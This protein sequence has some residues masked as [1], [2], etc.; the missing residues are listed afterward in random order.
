[1]RL[2]FVLP[3]VFTNNPYPLGVNGSLW[4]IPLEVR[5]YVVLALAG[6]F[7]LMRSKSIWLLIIAAFIAWFIVKSS[8]DVTGKIHYGRELSAFFLVG[9]ALFVLQSRW[10]RRPMLWLL[11]LS[12]GAALV[13]WAGWHYTA[14]LI[15]LPFTVIYA[16]TR[17]TPVIQHFGRWGD[18]SYGIY[19][20]AY[21]VQ[22]TVIHFL[23]PN[24]GFVG[25]MTLASAITVVLA[26]AS[27]HGVEKTALKFKPHKR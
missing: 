19:L 10:E 11:A 17:S 6:F 18:P 7:G 5:C 22:Q 16:G 3:G 25:T 24:L 21:P 27:W 14:L 1:M 9:S 12:A 2:H 15:L 13:W 20:I 23:W 26:Y 8:P 4:T